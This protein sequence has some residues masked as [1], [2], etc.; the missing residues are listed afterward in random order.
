MWIIVKS[1]PLFSGLERS[2][3]VIMLVV[4]SFASYKEKGASTSNKQHSHQGCYAPPRCRIPSVLTPRW[5]ELTASVFSWIFLC[6]N[7][8]GKIRKAFSPLFQLYCEITKISSVSQVICL[9]YSVSSLLLF[10][11]VLSLHS[12]IANPHHEPDTSN[13]K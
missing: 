6:S 11:N 7:L 10:V 8:M 9:F 1:Y 12:E 4:F 3:L 2:I 5:C 13:T